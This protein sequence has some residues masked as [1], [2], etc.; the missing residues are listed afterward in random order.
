MRFLAGLLIVLFSVACGGGGGGS[1]SSSEPDTQGSS[2]SNDW[3]IDTTFVRDGGP[4]K[5]GIPALDSPTFITAEQA[6]FISDFELVVGTNIEGVTRAIPHK[7]M[8]WH[9]VLTLETENKFHAFSY[10][11]L[12]GSAGLWNV[13]ENFTNKTFGVSGLLYNSNLILYDRET[14]SNWPQML[15]Q[16]ANGSLQGQTSETNAVI[17]TTWGSWKQM[18]PDTLI[19]SANTGFSRDYQLYPYGS[20][21][22]DTNLLFDVANS[23]DRLHLKTRILGV[24]GNSVNKI[25]EIADFNNGI[26]IINESPSNSPY[27]VAG[28]SD[29]NFAIAFDSTLADGTQL[30]FTPLEAAL[31]II[32]QDNEGNQWN[33]FGTAVSGNRTG[34]QLKMRSDYIA[35]WFAWVAIHPNP[36]IHQF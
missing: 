18:Y 8:N 28:S 27:V 11:P 30:T 15:N 34:E 21:L 35:F 24:L 16:S 29:L 9:E 25:Y 17:E 13:P 6:T 26:H 31:P 2:S 12:T 3:L 4:G 32:M 36:V 10:C 22:S 14:D 1:S 7:I 33:I 20:Y 23:D 5:D 19:L